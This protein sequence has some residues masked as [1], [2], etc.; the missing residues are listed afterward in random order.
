[1]IQCPNCKNRH[2][3]A[4]NLSWFTETDDEPKN[5]EQMVA[6]KG[7][8]IRKGVQYLDGKDHETIEIFSDE[9]GAETGESKST[10]KV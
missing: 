4:D 9:G 8:R 3:I 7:G 6:A 5:V 1:L 2:L 10:K